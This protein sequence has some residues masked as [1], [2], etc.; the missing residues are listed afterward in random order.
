MWITASEVEIHMWINWGENKVV[1]LACL[2][3]YG[4]SRISIVGDPEMNS[5]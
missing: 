2:P 5:G 4:G 1:T 3:A